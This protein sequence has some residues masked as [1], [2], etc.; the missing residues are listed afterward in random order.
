M[1]R[2]W[3]VGVAVGVALACAQSA[4]ADPHSGGPVLALVP[5]VAHSVAARADYRFRRVDDGGFY[6]G[7]GP[8]W[9]WGP[10][11]T[12]P[13]MYYSPPPVIVTPPPRITYIAPERP[14]PRPYY[15]YY[16]ESSKTY[17]PY[18]KKCP[19][20]W[21]KVVPHPPRGAR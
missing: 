9:G 19:G 20:G 16:C 12:P 14:R 1:K 8:A 7:M 6:F 13:P 2:R 21:M 3:I 5:A 4:G 17:Y 11:W 10:W 15:W 18:V